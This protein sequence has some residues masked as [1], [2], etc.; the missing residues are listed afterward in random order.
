MRNTKLNLLTFVWVKAGVHPKAVFWLGIKVLKQISRS[1]FKQS[2]I[3][4]L[5]SHIYVA[6][7]LVKFL[8]IFGYI[9]G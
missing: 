3:S 9:W 7:L 4:M 8:V 1:R 2:K 5:I 6:G